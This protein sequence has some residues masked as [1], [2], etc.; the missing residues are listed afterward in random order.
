MFTG[1]YAAALAA[2]A[3]DPKIPLW[4]AV[5]G[6]QLLD[7]GWSSLV[8]AGVEKVRIVPSLPGSNLDLYYMPFTHSLP[9]AL[10]WSVAGTAA[11]RWL[12]RLGWTSASLLGAVVFSHWAL[13]FLVHRPDLELFPHGDKV[14]LAL[15]NYPL[16][17]M[18]LE[19][20]LVGLAGAALA[21]TKK[22]QGRS[23][24]PIVA[25]IGVLTIVQIIASLMSQLGGSAPAEP[26]G[27]A[28]QA[29][30]VYA[31]IAVV[32]AAVDREGGS[33]RELS[34]A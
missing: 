7:F 31:A 5:V 34:I 29:L 3:A 16:A 27:F 28:L 17:E 26:A 1:H 11:G 25:F 12:L 8:M 13:D 19:L 14:G 6:C 9:A 4:S 10:L 15:W 20:G 22:A 2:K 24:W 33:T 30:V 32:A 18:A 21:A 23:A